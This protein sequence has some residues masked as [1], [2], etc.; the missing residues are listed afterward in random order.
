M[1][2]KEEK[3]KKALLIAII[4]GLLVLLAY[5]L[6]FE[7][8]KI[9]KEKIDTKTISIVTDQSDFYTISSCVS[10]YLNYLC[11]D[12]SK[13]L[14][15]LLSDEYKKENSI[16]EDNINDFIDFLDGLYS[17]NP[18]KMYVQRKSKNVYKFYVYGLI[19]Q[20]LMDIDSVGSDYYI[21]IILDKKNGTFAV[22]PYSGEMFK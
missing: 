20:D 18:K 19:E 7:H 21:I 15:I 22:E 1:I 16:T 17:F 2:L 5:K 11:S 8:K 14:I 12:D 10:K 3:D 13:D 6:F 4:L 9:I